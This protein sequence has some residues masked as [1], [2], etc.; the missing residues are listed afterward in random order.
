M[1][2][3]TLP[4]PADDLAAFTRSA[5][6]RDDQVDRFDRLLEHHRVNSAA[7]DVPVCPATHLTNKSSSGLLNPS[8]PR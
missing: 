4:N 3:A 5:P 7:W 6:P 1:R 8:L 2:N